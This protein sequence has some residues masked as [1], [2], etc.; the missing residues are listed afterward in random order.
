[1][2]ERV[3]PTDLWAHLKERKLIPHSVRLATFSKNDAGAMVPEAE[4]R[5]EHVVSWELTRGDLERLT[6]V[7]QWQADF[8]RVGLAAYWGLAEQGKQ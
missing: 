2:L 8:Q 1:M 5:S 4:F 7:A 6:K 3:I